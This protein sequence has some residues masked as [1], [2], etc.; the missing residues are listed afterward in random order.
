MPDTAGGADQCWA[1]FQHQRRVR[2]EKH[3]ANAALPS[4][5]GAESYMDGTATT[6]R[7]ALELLPLRTDQSDF[8]AK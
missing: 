4:A 8:S 3:R 6:P 5:G 1:Y 2:L 7:R